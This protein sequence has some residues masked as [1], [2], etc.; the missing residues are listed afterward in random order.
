NSWAISSAASSPPARPSCWSRPPSR[1]PNSMP[2]WRRSNAC[3]TDSS[4]SS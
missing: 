3:S 4:C 1:S 2:R